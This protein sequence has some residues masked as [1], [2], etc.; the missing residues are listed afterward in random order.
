MKQQ[1]TNDLKSLLSGTTET[2]SPETPPGI[3]VAEESKSKR[4]SKRQGKKVV[5]TFVDKSFHK[6]LKLLSIEKEMYM[7]D[8]FTEA[9]EL[10]LQM[11][12]GKPLTGG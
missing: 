7:E 10:Y 2:E 1:P 3:E 6:Q 4:N 12:Q 8:L 5:V 9:L 11:H